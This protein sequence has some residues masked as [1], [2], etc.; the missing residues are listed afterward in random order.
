MAS[1]FAVHHAHLFALEL[2][3][4]ELRALKVG[5]DVARGIQA[6][7][8]RTFVEVRTVGDLLATR[9]TDWSTM[10]M[11]LSALVG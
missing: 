8:E 11:I 5:G 1:I 4:E 10:G 2:T 6:D 7:G 3:E 9:D